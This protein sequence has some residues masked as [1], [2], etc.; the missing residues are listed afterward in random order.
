[1]LMKKICEQIEKELISLKA[2]ALATYQA[3]TDEEAKPENKYDTRALEA[4]YLAGAQALRVRE[5]EDLLNVYRLLSLPSYSMDQTI[6]PA[7]LVRLQFAQKQI[8]VF[9]LPKGGGLNVSVGSQQIQ[10]VTP[11]SPL[12]EA[13]VG[14]GVG[15]SAIVEV[16][17]AVKEY[18][19]LEIC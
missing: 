10:V 8:L 9:M 4:S 17:A 15:D 14:L 7:A 11:A 6:G 1:M 12:G 5:I 3:A 13:L 16:G 19:I 18:E 2:A